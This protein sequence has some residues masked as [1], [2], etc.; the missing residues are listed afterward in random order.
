MLCLHKH[1]KLS[2]ENVFLFLVV[3]G[4]KYITDRNLNDQKPSLL[5]VDHQA[6]VNEKVK[7]L[8]FGLLAIPSLYY[9]LYTL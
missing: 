5:N 4:V 9:C 2:P 8:I 6:T 7:G 3:G 1:I